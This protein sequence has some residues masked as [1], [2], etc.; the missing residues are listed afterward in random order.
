MKHMTPLLYNLRY[1]QTL[2][3]G[4]MK[5]TIL[6]ADRTDLCIAKEWL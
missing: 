3:A 6:E 5:V 2:I 1:V 4:I